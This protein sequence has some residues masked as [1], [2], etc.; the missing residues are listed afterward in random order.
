[1]IDPSPLGIATVVYGLGLSVAAETLGWPAADD[2]TGA[3]DRPRP[4]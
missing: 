2:V 3:F 1:M 4:W